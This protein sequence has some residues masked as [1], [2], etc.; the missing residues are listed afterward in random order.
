MVDGMVLYGKLKNEIKFIFIH[1]I[2]F[3]WSSA[4]FF[5]SVLMILHLCPCWQCCFK[6]TLS[7]SLL[8][9]LQFC[10]FGGI[11]FLTL[12]G[13]PHIILWH[14]FSILLTLWQ[15]AHCHI[16]LNF[17]AKLMLI[18]LE[19]NLLCSHQFLPWIVF[20]HYLYLSA[21]CSLV[22]RHSIIKC[23]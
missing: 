2:A 21:E 16:I 12:K 20:V 22:P 10:Q 5:E 4:S 1:Y 6:A 18:F 15:V 13:L 3:S 9:V 19:E 23:A 14:P 8:K 11:L 7:S 17:P